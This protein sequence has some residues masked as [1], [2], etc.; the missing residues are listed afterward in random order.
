MRFGLVHDPDY[1]RTY[2]KLS[3]ETESINIAADGRC[4]PGA[5]KNKAYAYQR[6]AGGAGSLEVLMNKGSGQK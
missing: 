1:T 5:P 4:I 6:L 3:I 2:Y